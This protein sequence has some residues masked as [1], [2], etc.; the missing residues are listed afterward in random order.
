MSNNNSKNEIGNVMELVTSLE[1]DRR[2]SR[3]K[4]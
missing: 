2:V 3:N 1:L 4:R